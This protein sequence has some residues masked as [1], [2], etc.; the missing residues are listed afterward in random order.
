MK[1]TGS[2]RKL[3]ENSRQAIVGAIETYN[4]PKFDYREEVF[5]ILLTNAWELLFLAILS[6]IKKEYLNLKQKTRI[7][8]L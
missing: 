4:K 8:K 5:S 1:V 3:L 6:K 2:W 7:L